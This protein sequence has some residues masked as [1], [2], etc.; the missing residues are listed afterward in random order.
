MGVGSGRRACSEPNRLV[1]WG[2]ALRIVGR[3]FV[4]INRDTFEAT[5]EPPR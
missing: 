4:P 1:K 2:Q 5:D 3:T